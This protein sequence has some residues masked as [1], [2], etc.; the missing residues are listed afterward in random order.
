[1]VMLS[2]CSGALRDS[3]PESTYIPDTNYYL[4]MAEIALQRQAYVTAAEQYLNAAELSVDPELAERATEFAIL[5]G[6]ETFALSGARR[7]LELEAENRVAHEHAGRLY[8]RRYDNDQAYTHL[9]ALLGELPN[10]EAFL[11]LSAALASEGN[12]LGVTTVFKRFARQYPDSAGLQLALARAA[13]RSGEYELALWAARKADE[14]MDGADSPESQ[15]LVAQVLMAQGSEVEALDQIEDLRSATASIAVELEYVRLLSVSGR[16]AQANEQLANLA[17]TYGV[18]PDFVRIHALINLAA[19]DLDTAEQD[20]SQLLSAGKNVYENLYYL[21]RIAISRGE[22]DA[23]IDYFARVRGGPYLLQAR[24]SEALAYQQLGEPQ[25]ALDKLQAFTQTNPRH[26]LAVLPTQAQLLFGLGE[27]QQALAT[28][29][30]LLGY[31]PDSIDILL[32]YG[33]MLDQAGELNRSLDVMRHAV[34]LAPMDANVLNTLG[35]TLANRTRHHSE[36]HRLIRQALELTPDS[37]AVI[38]SMGWVLY[39]LGRKQEALSYLEQ[40]YALL[41]DP[42]VI[43]HLGELLWVTGEQESARELLERS[44]VEYPDHELIVETLEE[45]L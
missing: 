27:T 26:A 12:T 20:F 25:I 3:A 43:A 18:Q 2:A 17:K 23:G 28:F 11:A 10:D 36:A 4:L 30:E 9:H 32:A 14:A 15:L 44:L 8:L 42:E 6:Y 33:G 39:R 5:Y 1:M 16:L 34:E 31:Q 38:D 35:Y 13:I 22:Y 7:W 40:A 19:G 21:G 24:M 41:D 29:D 37:P 45:L